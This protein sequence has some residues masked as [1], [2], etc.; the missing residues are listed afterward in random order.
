MIATHTVVAI[1]AIPMAVISIVMIVRR[2][3][4]IASE[5]HTMIVE[6]EV[7]ASELVIAN[8]RMMESHIASVV[9][10]MSKI[11]VAM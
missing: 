4:M 9:A 6:L 2:L 10:V 7:I 1:V 11:H 5:A 3:V 8:I